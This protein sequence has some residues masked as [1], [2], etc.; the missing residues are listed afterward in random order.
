[1]EVHERR[2]DWYQTSDLVE[3]GQGDELIIHGRQD[4]VVKVGGELVNL[5][6]LNKRRGPHDA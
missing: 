1:M 2:E 6:K 3:L 5:T 4:E